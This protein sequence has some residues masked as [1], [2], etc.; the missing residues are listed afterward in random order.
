MACRAG[1]CRM[2]A[3]QKRGDPVNQPEWFL[4]KAGGAMDMANQNRIKKAAERFA[5][6]KVVVIL[7]GAEAE[8]AGLNAETFINGGPALARPMLLPTY[9]G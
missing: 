9:D 5:A 8:S 2:Y 4:G 3:D 6:D 1:H 7:G